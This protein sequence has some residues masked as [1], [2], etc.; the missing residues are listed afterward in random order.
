MKIPTNKLSSLFLSVYKFKYLTISLSFAV[1]QIQSALAQPPNTFYQQ[2]FIKTVQLHKAGWS[3]TYPIIQLHSPEQ[4][5]LSFDDLSLNSRNYNYS[6]VHC[7]FNWEESDMLET[8]YLKGFTQNPLLD[9]QFSFNTTFTYTHH[10]L[11]FPNEDMQISKS[12]NYLIKIYED[13]NKDQPVLIQPFMV[14]EPRVN[15]VPQVKYSTNTSLIKAM[16]EVDFSVFHPK[17]NI[18]NPIE[19]VKVCIQ[20]NGRTDNRITNLKP[21]FIRAGELVYDYNRENLFEGGNE[22]RWLDIRSTR[23]APEYVKAIHFYDPHYHFE[24]FPDNSRADKSYF[25]REDFNGRYYIEVRENRDPEIEADYVY[26]HFKH[27]ATYPYSTG[28]VFISGALSNWQLDTPNQME[29]NPNSQSYELTLLLKQGFYNYQYIF[30][31]HN[32]GKGELQKIEGSFGQTENDYLILVY[33]RS[34]GDYYD[35]LVGVSTVNSLKYKPVK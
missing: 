21:V 7:D 27:P 35:Q 28:D 1:I 2:S 17:L 33:Y 3:R 20:Q 19:E 22:F 31:P 18:N 12:G 24:L 29:Y 26:V 25:Y 11:L 6:I 16:Q 14:F 4:L 23:F 10:K 30:K 13:N 9:Y 5:E 15:I 32:Q 34:L 8:E